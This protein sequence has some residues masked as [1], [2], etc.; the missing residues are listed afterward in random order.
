M[1]MHFLWFR[2]LLFSDDAQASSL[3][4]Q[5]SKPSF[6]RD[7]AAGVVRGVTSFLDICSPFAHGCPSWFPLTIFPLRDIL[8]STDGVQD[9]EVVIWRDEVEG[10]R[11]IPDAWLGA[12]HALSSKFKHFRGIFNPNANLNFSAVI[13]PTLHQIEGHGLTFHAGLSTGRRWFAILEARYQNR[14]GIGF[15]TF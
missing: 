15:L 1:A 4:V 5:R 8:F 10:A 2:H 9:G 3:D 14:P 7:E 11:S 13:L 6:S 12:T